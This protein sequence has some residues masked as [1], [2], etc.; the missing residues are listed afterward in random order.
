MNRLVA[1]IMPWNGD[2]P[3]NSARAAAVCSEI[4]RD[5]DIPIFAPFVCAW[6]SDADPEDRAAGMEISRYLVVQCREA[7]VV[8]DV[9][10]GM[11]ADIEAAE[12]ARIPIRRM[13]ET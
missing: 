11:I 4:Q 6:L 5:G 1:V 2:I 9:T 10:P 13:E 7:V 8:G 3:A 12:M